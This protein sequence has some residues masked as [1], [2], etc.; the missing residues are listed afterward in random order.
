MRSGRWAPGCR[1]SSTQRRLTT[2]A[3]TA[4]TAIGTFESSELAVKTSSPITNSR[5]RPKRSASDPVVSS[6]A[7][8]INANAST[9]HCGSVKLAFSDVSIAGSATFT[10]VTSSSSMNVPTH[11]G[12]QGPPLAIH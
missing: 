7:A 6:S 10:I 11:Y 5:R 2:T 12:D 1:D 9:T 8:S 3:T 4:T